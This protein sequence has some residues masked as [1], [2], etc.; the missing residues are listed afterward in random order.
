MEAVGDPHVTSIWGCRF[1][2][3]KN[4]TQVTLMSCEDDELQIEYNEEWDYHIFRVWT[5]VGGKRERYHKKALKHA[6]VK[7]ICGNTVEFHR[8][9]L[10][11]NVRGVELSNREIG[12]LF[13]D[14]RC[15]QDW[16]STQALVAQASGKN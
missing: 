9:H 13:N 6:Q 15:V 8:Y 3:D 4:Q 14:S 2:A 10:G 1:E 12:G 7:R 16:H 5:T 11:I